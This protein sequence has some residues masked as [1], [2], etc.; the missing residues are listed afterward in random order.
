MTATRKLPGEGGPRFHVLNGDATLALLRKAAVP[1]E[2]I[3]FPDMLM[4]GP[5]PRGRGGRL[6]WPSRAAFLAARYGVPRAAALARMR[7]F[8]KALDA[9]LA[10]GGEVTFWFEEDFFCQV[11]LAYLL[12]TLPAPALR[13]VRVIRS[14]KPLGRLS[15]K[16]LERRFARRLPVDPACAALAKKLWTALSRPAGSAGKGLASAARHAWAA[17]GRAEALL[18]DRGAFA[19]WPRLRAGLKAQLA[20]RPGADGLGSLEKALLA[21]LPKGGRALP[22]AKVFTRVAGHPR[23]RPLGVGDLQVAR[24]ALD[25]ARL[26]DAPLRIEGAGRG[27]KALEGLALWRLSLP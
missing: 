13:R 25:L 9:A 10:S 1:G 8:Q 14:A 2:A 11:H 27:R 5:L 7:A 19:P 4:E 18:A 3:V 17:G 16:D 23:A 15:P 12:A 6:D 21:A 20:R 24:C 26:P 22:F